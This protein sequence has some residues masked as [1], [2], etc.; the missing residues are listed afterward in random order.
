MVETDQ[1]AEDVRA[2]LAN[3]IANIKLD[4]DENKKIQKQ[5]KKANASLTQELKECKST[6]AETSRTLGESNSIR[7]SCLIALQNKQTELE[8]YMAFNDRTVDYDKLERKLN[9]TLGLLAQKEIDIK[10]GLKL[11]AYEISIVKE[12]HDELVK[13]SLLTKSHFEELVDQAWEKHSHNHF[14]ASTALDMEVLIK[15]CLM[16]LAI[17]TQNDSFIFVHELKQE[18]H[19]DLKH[20]IASQVGV[21][22]DLTKPFTPHSLPQVRKSYFAKPYDVNAPGPSRNSPK[23]VSFQSPKESV[24]S[25]DMVHNYYL[26][27]AKKKAQLQKDKALNTKPSVQQY[28]RLPNTANGNKPKPKPKT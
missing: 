6:L 13:Q 19:A 9:E 8:K 18:M 25:N 14:H 15:T 2:A 1:N 10:E 27:E 24:G 16:L 3:L 4:I 21:F 28:A 22:H 11:K 12:K 23:H 26:E 20:R 5:L 17:K 7:D